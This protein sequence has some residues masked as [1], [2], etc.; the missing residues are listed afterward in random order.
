MQPPKLN[1]KDYSR[2][3]TVRQLVLPLDYSQMIP[4]TEAVRLLDAVLE[5]LD[6]TALLR[7]YSSQGRKSTVPPKTLFK[8][9]VFAM[10]EGIYSL[11]AIQRQC[12]V[13]IQYMW[14]LQ[15]Y[16]APSH[17][18]IGRFYK[19]LTVPVQ[20]DLFAQFIHVLSEI[21][22][23][24]MDEVYIDG[25][26]LEANANRYSFVWRKNIE[27]GLKKLREK[28]PAF[29]EKITQTL[30]P[31]AG[32]MKDTELLA[33]LAAKCQEE[34]VCFVSGKGHRK[35]ALQKTFE[36]CEALCEKRR[37]Y[38][39]HLSVLRERNSYSKTDPDATFMR[40]KDDHMR[41]GQ[42][43]PA[44]NV[45]LAVESEYIVGV[46]IF[47]NPTD[48]LTLIPFLKHMDSHLNLKPEYVVADAGYDSEE[49][50]DWLQEHEYKSVI[51]PAQYEISKKKQYKKRID[52][53]ANMKY[54][55]KKDEYTCAKGRKLIF[56][57]VR[58]KKHRSG[59]VSESYVYRC[60]NCQYCGLRKQCQRQGNRKN[61]KTI[62]INRNYNELQ[63]DNMER[64][65]SEEGIQLRVNRS[66][67]VEGAFG[68]IKQDY[69]YKRILRRGKEGVYKEL[70]FLALGFN[71]RKLH[72]R[73]QEE[74]VNL[75]FLRKTDKEEAC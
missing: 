21:D 71:I 36:E 74:R 60:T 4:E 39:K 22:A 28:Y 1:H 13:N 58:K 42:L 35:P 2:F 73:I 11:R 52:L 18:A 54:D 62:Q 53:P 68:Q 19:R 46:G 48:T 34:N 32:S 56:E 31:E 45:Q 67:Q 29:R 50:L 24:T 66:I 37:E 16:K 30:L 6:Y 9:I 47:P 55:P 61:N 51:K 33:A 23:V 26:K 15:G 43:K 57:A 17:M 40:M 3:S 72:N 38:E 75:R 70:L 8:I 63:Q 5:E 41:N 59:Y 44:Y 20:E 65:L 25:T 49:N 10:L 12:Q 7:L 69:S 64:F 14:L 27:R